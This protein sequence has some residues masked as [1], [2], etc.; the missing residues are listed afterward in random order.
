MTRTTLEKTRL[1]AFA[2]GELSPEEAAEVVMHLADHPEDQAYVDDLMA[3]NAALAAAFAAPLDEPVPPRLLAAAGAPVAQVVPLRRPM[4]RFVPG[5][6]ALAAS[7]AAAAVLFWPATQDGLRPGAVAQGS[8]LA[9]ALD[10]LASGVPATLDGRDLMILASLPVAEGYCREV[11]VIDRAAALLEMALA[12]RD[13]GGWRV[14]AVLS[15][16]LP[17][18]ASGGFVPAGGADTAGLTPFLDRLG[19]GMALTPDEEAAAIAA[20]WTK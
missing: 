12:C 11:E 9:Q 3:A 7:V 10:G 19:A 8:A 1:A 17:E 15:E 14:E 18:A 16:P 6:L 5:A 2:D 20:G 4:V 13:A